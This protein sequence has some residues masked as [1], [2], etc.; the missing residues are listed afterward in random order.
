MPNK[1]IYI[2]DSDVPLWDRAQNELGESISSAFVDFLKGRLESMP[3]RRK[4][5]KLD[6]VQAIDGVLAEINATR[7]LDIERHP[8]WSPI[9][10]DANSV[11]IGY[12][13]HQKRANPD[14]IMS[15]IVHPLDFDEDGQLNRRTRKRVIAEI[16]KFWDGRSTCQHRLVDTTRVDIDPNILVHCSG[17]GKPIGPLFLPQPQGDIAPRAITV[18]AVPVHVACPF[19][20]HVYSY[21]TADMEFHDLGTPDTRPIP[22]DRISAHVRRVCGVNG[23]QRIVVIHTTVKRGSPT[24]DLMQ[25]PSG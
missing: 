2:K 18:G 6:M 24:S 1:T 12:K 5:G 22:N 20:G 7:N 9:V 11:N 17:C 15:L 16:E 4:R 8:S 21:R 23:C 14:R 10:L 25:A 13:L 3:K 19:C